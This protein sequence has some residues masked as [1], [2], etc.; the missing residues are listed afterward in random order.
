MKTV[1]QLLCED[2]Y[3]L[4]SVIVPVYN[5]E[6][7]LRKCLD[8]IIGQTY[9]NL[10][11]LLIDD[12][13]TDH[14]GDICDDYE[15]RDER[16]CVFHTENGG[17]SAARNLGL[18]YANGEYIGFVDSD[19]W[20][21]PDMYEVLFHSATETGA[22]I[23]EC[24]FYREYPDK[25]LSVVRPER[26][27]SSGEAIR[28]LLRKELSEGVWSKLWK[29]HCF[30]RIRFPV[31]RVHEDAST[32]YLVFDAVTSICSISACEYH[33]LQRSGS[34]LHTYNSNNLVGYWLARKE[35]Y[36]FLWNRVDEAARKDLLRLCALA[37]ARMWAHYYEC[38]K[39]ERIACKRALC[40]INGFVRARIP[41][42]GD[43][44]WIPLLRIGAVFPHFNNCVS[45]LVA[46]LFNQMR[47]RIGLYRT[48]AE[49]P[50]TL[51][52]TRN[53]KVAPSWYSDKSQSHVG[54]ED[55]RNGY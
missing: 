33:Y 18:D 38:S 21:E 31:G 30:D 1:N 7:Y 15:K 27:L 49:A 22:D 12:G 8:S 43:R 24:G 3:S 47:R 20:I 14:S 16:I 5:V 48:R 2:G 10:E 39:K 11:I 53:A 36:D 55:R 23:V 41:L 26:M 51:H 34:I 25:S 40:D 50:E 19:D 42:F 35:Q 4:V 32:T 54:N 13:S 52:I 44:T 6:P 29:R 45:L 37:A 9:E 28:A 46:R 17:L